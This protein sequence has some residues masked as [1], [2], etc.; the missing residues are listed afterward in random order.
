[1]LNIKQIRENPTAVQAQ[2]DFRGAGVYDL[3]PILA[4]DRQQRE[5][6]SQR[7]QLQARSNEIGKLVGEKIK[8][9]TAPNSP[10]IQ[11]LKDEGNLN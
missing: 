9:G 4:L 7:G 8:S 6:E 3:Q 5:L 1:V 2:L 10:E 11:S